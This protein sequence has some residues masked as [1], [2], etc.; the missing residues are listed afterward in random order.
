MARSI[1]LGDGSV[2]SFSAYRSA[3]GGDAL[4][5]AAE[6]GPAAVIDRIRRSGLRGRGGA[7]FPTGVKW[8]GTANADG[9][10]RFLVCNAA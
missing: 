2:A 5:M 10:R 1:L 8:S 6:I 4:T 9:D 3:G 7:G